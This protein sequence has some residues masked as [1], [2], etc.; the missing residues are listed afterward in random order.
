MGTL[1]PL[2]GSR[3]FTRRASAFDVTRDT[4]TGHYVPTFTESSITGVLQQQNGDMPAFA[5]G[6]VMTQSAILY[7]RDTV[8]KLDEIKDG[9]TYYKVQH[10]EEQYDKADVPN[11][12]YRA[13][14]LQLMDIHINPAS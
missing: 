12:V 3:T 11:L 7:T 2:P 4:F 6:V 14:H 5:V 10:I 9:T 1:S 13:C 8:V